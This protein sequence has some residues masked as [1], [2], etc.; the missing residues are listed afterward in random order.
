MAF[1]VR[2]RIVAAGT[3]ITQSLHHGAL[4]Q[5]LRVMHFA[6]YV[7]SRI[8]AYNVLWRAA[9]HNVCG[10]RPPALSLVV[11]S[12]V[13][14]GRSRCGWLLPALHSV[15]QQYQLRFP[16]LALKYGN[17]VLFIAF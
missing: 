8:V 6:M 17:S 5:T 11:V 9:L 15:K 12:G 14:L 4:E 2:R 16:P 7:A 1:V 3:Q 13:P 10:Q